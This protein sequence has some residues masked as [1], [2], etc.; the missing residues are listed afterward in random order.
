[1]KYKAIRK[2]HPMKLVEMTACPAWWNLYE[3]GPYGFYR[4]DKASRPV[5]ADWHRYP[6]VG[7]RLFGLVHKGQVHCFLAA[8]FRRH[9]PCVHIQLTYTPIRFRGKGY[10]RELR[11]Q[12]LELA[13]AE[14]IQIVTV[15]CQTSD[16][17]ALFNDG[18][19]AAVNKHGR[20]QKS[21]SLI[22]VVQP[23]VTAV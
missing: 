12:F 15:D 11:R 22:S 1:M 19:D 18:A 9:E 8:N 2:M 10:A 16:G 7:L 23:V 3:V 13:K 14:G 17:E 4:N 6:M 21:Y 20:P 5:I